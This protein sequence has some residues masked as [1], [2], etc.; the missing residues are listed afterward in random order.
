MGQ[1]DCLE[2]KRYSSRD[3]QGAIS[4]NRFVARYLPCG[5]CFG[6]VTMPPGFRGSKSTRM[7]VVTSRG[8]PSRVNGLYF[9]SRTVF[10]ASSCNGGCPEITRRGVTFP[11]FQMTTR[12]MTVV[13]SG[14]SPVV[15]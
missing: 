15:C 3:T 10:I 9:Q 4:L 5:Q 12:T 11:D 6:W 14:E 7:S 8:S 13:T 1:H 2:V